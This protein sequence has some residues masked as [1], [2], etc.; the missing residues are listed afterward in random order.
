MSALQRTSRSRSKTAPDTSGDHAGFNGTHPVTSTR[1]LSTET[2]ASTQRATPHTFSSENNPQIPAKITAGMLETLSAANLPVGLVQINGDAASGE[3]HFDDQSDNRSSSLSELADGLD[4]QDEP[5]PIADPASLYEEND[6]EAETER[7]ERTPRKLVRTGTNTTIA[8]ETIVERTPSKLSNALLLDQDES[9]PPSPLAI[10]EDGIAK[11][12]A[13]GE[14]DM[15]SVSLKLA[16]VVGSST[17]SLAD[18]AGKKRKRASDDSSDD[19]L[20]AEE[21][22]RKRSDNGREDPLNAEQAS[23]A[24]HSDQADLEE[25]G[26]TPEEPAVP[27]AAQQ[28]DIEETI[29]DVAEEAV[30]ELAAVAKLPK[31]RKGGKRKGRK[32]A[33]DSAEELATNAEDGAEHVEGEHDEDD[34]GVM[35]EELNKKKTAIESLA[36]IE[37]KFKIFRE[38]YCDESLAQITKELEL[39]KQPHCTHPEYLTMVQCVDERRDAKVDYEKRLAGFK[40]NSLN[41]RSM[42]ERHQLHG[43]YF[44]AVREIREKF[45]SECNERIYQLQKGRRQMG[46]DETVYAYA[47]PEKRSTQVQH[48]T[49]YNHEVSVL[50]GIAKYVGFPAA[51]N[52]TPARS[53]DID[54]DLRAMKIPVRPAP[55]TFRPTYRPSRADEAAAEEQFIEQTPWANPRHPDH[56]AHYQAVPASASRNISQTYQTPAGQR[57]MIDVHVPNGSASTIDMA[58]NPPSSA[59][60]QGQGGH[61]RTPADSPV[62]QMKRN[63]GRPDVPSPDDHRLNSFAAISREAYQNNNHHLYSSPAGVHA[64]HTPDEREPTHAASV[65]PRWNG[66]GMRHLTAA[67]PPPGR[68]QDPRTDPGRAPLGQRNSLGAVSVGSG[69]ALFGR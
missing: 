34:G 54:D 9:G 46:V 27:T 5:T 53:S 59:A 8:S 52:I 16:E 57:R 14:T 44:Q 3:D 48:Q 6:S 37:K 18:M 25:E 64:E 35:D 15:N 28:L 29:A 47:F 43:Q 51:P 21:P 33:N 30:N 60:A 32:P 7:L 26:D 20:E 69:S 1:P 42:A 24:D 61:D 2:P 39:L 41:V 36:E 56:Q 55:P 63:A 66:A 11:D 17:D 45:I 49:A 22:A 65:A 23:N 13:D 50:S 4:D 58:S 31:T 38:K 62:M 68:A 67:A 19:E 12:I 10:V 40:Q